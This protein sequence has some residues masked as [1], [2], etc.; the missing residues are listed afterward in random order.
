M[1]QARRIIQN[2]HTLAGLAQ[3]QESARGNG[4]W[5][6]EVQQMLDGKAIE[7]GLRERR[8]AIVYI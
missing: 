6:E 5:T 8:R 1:E 4:R 7:L 3:I 2:T